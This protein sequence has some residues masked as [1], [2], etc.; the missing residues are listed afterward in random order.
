MKLYN[1]W[2]SSSSWRVRIAL[3]FKGLDYDY[4]PVHLVKDGGEQR[5]DWFA[6]KNPAMQVPLLE[7]E[8]NGKSIALSQSMAI[9]DF[10]EQSHPE[11]ALLPADPY[12]RAHAVQLAELINSGTQ[13]LQNLT[14]IQKFKAQGWDAKLW[15]QQAITTGLSAFEA[16]LEHSGD[17]CVGDSPTWADACLIPQLYNARRFE[18]DVSQWDKISAIEERALAHPAFAA[19]HPDQQPDAQ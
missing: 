19:A 3:N 14:V 6:K 17:F 10:L 5:L 9:L 2:R 12:L 8:H 4:I 1:Y 11:P 16:T 18:L 13:P 15:C 7:V